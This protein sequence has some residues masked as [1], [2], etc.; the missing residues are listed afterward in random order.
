MVVPLCLHRVSIRGGLDRGPGRSTALLGS[1]VNQIFS[2][3][4][5]QSD[6]RAL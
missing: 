6:V 1:I 2:M 3:P 5:E 4:L